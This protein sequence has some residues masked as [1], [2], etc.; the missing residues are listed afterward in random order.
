MIKDLVICA[1]IVLLSNGLLL[2]SAKT[3]I[4]NHSSTGFPGNFVVGL[5]INTQKHQFRN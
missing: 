2:G 5:H 3:V 4:L 1:L